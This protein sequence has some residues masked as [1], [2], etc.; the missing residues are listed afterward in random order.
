MSG[1]SW[2]NPN[3]Q[4]IFGE[5]HF[6]DE[7]PTLCHS[8]EPPVKKSF[9]PKDVSSCSFVR[10][11]YWK[12]IPKEKQDEINDFIKSNGVVLW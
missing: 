7:D 4:I 1:D 2:D 11:S 5:C 6:K 10:E 8:V 12:R 9:V 3:L